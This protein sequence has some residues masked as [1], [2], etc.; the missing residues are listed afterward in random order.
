MTRERPHGTNFRYRFGAT[1][2]D[3]RN[4]CRCYECSQAGVLYEK[5]RAARKARGVEPFVDNSDARTHLEWLGRNGV[6]MRVVADRTGLRRLTLQKIAS[7]AVRKSR[8][9]TVERILGCH[10]G[11]AAPGA[12]VDA[13][14]TLRLLD[15]LVALGYSRLYLAR[16]LNPNAHKLQ[17]GRSGRV[18]RATADQVRDL[19]R[20]LTASRDA[21][22]DY[23]ARRK[24]DERRRA[25]RLAAEVAS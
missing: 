7:G 4:G 11:F 9:D 14:D 15:E 3:W 8:P 22:R 13:A 10:L 17:V 16:Q 18:R 23:N 20:Q 12:S 25:R 2:N 1:G 21:H 19:H 5:L 24:A 6:G